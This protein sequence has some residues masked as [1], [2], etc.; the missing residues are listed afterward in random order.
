MIPL[1]H[2]MLFSFQSIL[3]LAIVHVWETTTNQREGCHVV[4]AAQGVLVVDVGSLVYTQSFHYERRQKKHVMRE[5]G[6][7]EET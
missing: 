4:R 5:K 1:L 7:N 2:A 3:H 6:Y